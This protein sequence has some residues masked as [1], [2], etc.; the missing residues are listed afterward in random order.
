VIACG[1]AAQAAPVLAQTALPPVLV[2]RQLAEEQKLSVGAVIDLS[3]QAEGGTSQRFQVVGL[4]EP[5]PDP[6]RLG[7]LPREV[8]LH[9]PD[10]LSLS[11]RPED[12]VGAEHVAAIN[13]ALIDPGEASRFAADVNGTVPGVA[14][15]PTGEASRSA[16][17]FVVLRRFHLAIAA[18]TIVAATIF[19]LALSVMLVEERRETVG[20]LRL[21][22]FP[23][24]RVLW[25][26]LL[27][28]FLISAAGAAFGLLLAVVLQ[29]AVNAFFQWRYDTALIFVRLT[30]EIAAFCLA[31]AV[32]L[33]A[34]STLVASWLLL[35]RSGLRL[36][37]R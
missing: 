6:S 18:V 3:A 4:Y 35:R 29:R 34:I 20:V 36:A 31:V 32:P 2:S 7:N 5:V 21:I 8:R 10:L 33:G 27:E 24:R 26:V 1:V 28:G 19:L 23:V 9:L 17:P 16:A 13:V 12:P 15:Q 37:R 14:A 25:Q 22:G 30:P 11:R